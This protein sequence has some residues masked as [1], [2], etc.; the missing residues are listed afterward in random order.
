MARVTFNGPI[1]QV[2]GQIGGGV[3]RVVN[4][5]PVMSRAPDFSHWI[6]SPDQ[7]ANCRKF[8]QAAHWTGARLQDPAC[9]AAYE[10]KVRPNRQRLMGALMQDAF[11][12]KA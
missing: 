6:L 12:P 10:A 8:G 3:Y 7:E 4:G 11:K 2:H 9:K 5:K 1:S